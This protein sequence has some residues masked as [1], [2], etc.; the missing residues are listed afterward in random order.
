MRI[1]RVNEVRSWC[2]C[3]CI[4]RGEKLFETAAPLP[5]GRHQIS[6]LLLGLG[7]YGTEMLKALAWFGQMDGYDLRLTAVD[8]R[9][10]ARELF[11]TAARS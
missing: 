4:S 1:R 8:A 9:P 3:C 6:A 11:T 7:Q 2:S 5:E 10:N